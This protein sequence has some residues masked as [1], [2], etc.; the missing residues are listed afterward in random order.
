M[1]KLIMPGELNG[2]AVGIILKEAM[3]RA[4]KR[5]IAHRLVF[6][7]REKT[8]ESGGAADFETNADTEA[9]AIY[10]RMLT[11]CFPGYGII[12]EEQRLRHPCKLPLANA[13][14]TVDP[15]DGTKAFMRRQSHGVG[16]MISLVVNGEV[17]CAYVGDINSREIY[18]FRPGSDSVFRIT[19][20]ETAQK[21]AI[22][23]ELTL[24]EQYLLL[25]DPVTN[26]SATTQRLIREGLF[27][28]HEIG[29]GS[30][31]IA[32]ARLWKG[33]VGA[34]ILQARHETPWDFSP[35]L[36][37]SEKMGFCFV[38]INTTNAKVERVYIMPSTE[39]LF[40]PSETLIVHSSRLKEIE[41]IVGL[42][43]S[44]EE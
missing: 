34:I 35:I 27:K 12:A 11:E 43:C 44:F 31:G 29:G 2:H 40:F 17:V 5:I 42:G 16:T 32:F 8:T 30:I 41:G 13:Y 7:A 38:G 24:D 28:N 25:R 15:L 20:Q 10:V 18:G 36:G 19:D 39:T 21:L 1:N 9:Q 6:E 3:R 22:D 26:H 23:P 14:F 4:M 37:I 33:E